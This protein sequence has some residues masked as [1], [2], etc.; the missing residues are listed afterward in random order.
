[1]QTIKTGVV[2]ALLMAVCYGAFVALNAPEPNLPDELLSEF[3]WNP[4]DADLEGLMNI[5]MPSSDSIATLDIQSPR[6]DT[7]AIGT[8]AA[9][10][11]GTFDNQNLKLPTLPSLE[12]TLPTS[13]NLSLPANPASLGGSQFASSSASLGNPQSSAAS[14]PT[15]AG[16]PTL[17][18]LPT[19]TI[20]AADGPA[21]ALNGSP[22]N[23][24]TTAQQRKPGIELQSTVAQG[25]L[26]S[27]TK[28]SP[29]T[30]LS[31]I[32][33][34]LLGGPTASAAGNDSSTKELP[35]LPFAA[36]R[37]QALEKASAGK[38]RDALQMLSS[39]Y[40]SPELNSTQHA[41]LVDLLDALSKEVIYS[42]RH[43]VEPPYAVKTTDTIESLSAK[44][45]INSELFARINRLGDSKALIDGSQVKILPG[46]F[47]AVVSLG[48]Q[49]LTVFMG[50]LY[51]G[52]FPVS[53]GRDPSPVEGTF[54]VVDRRRDRTYYGTGGKV[55]AAGDPRN[56]YGGYWL[57][58][59]QDLCIHGTPEMSSDDLQGA[60]CISL[61]P[62]DAGD[63][64]SIL[65]QS[66]Q[67]SI[68][69]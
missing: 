37:E 67:I 49:E 53:F 26:V 42:P 48:R 62:L 41:D 44:Y 60:G 8:P 15:L 25:Q 13:S 61:A 12:S 7:R 3:D 40:H 21:I 32:Q 29:A 22:S 54:E 30:D 18:A 28:A 56:P 24:S 64:Y 23:S 34:P 4:E 17:P 51:A 63:V 16:L 2:V 46:P 52:R 47:R 45:Q 33:L 35:A 69:R 9:G 6:S 68:V 43:L 58:L 36:A 5:E 38:L 65:S 66:S 1:M 14:G 11:F 10:G 31:G 57:N 59:G 20:A 50:E 19:G 39:Y 55:I 27:Q